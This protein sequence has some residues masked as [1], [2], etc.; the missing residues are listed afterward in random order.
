M[1][2]VPTAVAQIQ[3]GDQIVVEAKVWTVK[4]LEGPDRIGTYDLFLQDEQG[5]P[6]LEIANGSVTMVR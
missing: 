5:A 6:R 3:A 4:S 2:L 1:T